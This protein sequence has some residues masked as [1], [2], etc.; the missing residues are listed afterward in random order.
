MIIL[1]TDH[2]TL[3]RYEEN[4]KCEILSGRLKA[5][6]QRL[7]LTVISWEEQVRGWLA[8]INRSRTFV[9]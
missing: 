6:Q 9:D 1:D 5:S 3:L 2:L 8:E 4:P 7:A